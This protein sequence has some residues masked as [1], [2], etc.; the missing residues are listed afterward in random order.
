M[1]ENA[2]AAKCITRPE[3]CTGCGLCANVCPKDAIELVRNADGFL[4]PKVDETRC[5]NCGLC[6]RRCIAL[7]EGPDPEDDTSKVEA[8][9]AWNRDEEAHLQ[10]SSGGVFT[11]LA[12]QVMAEGGCVF[13]VVWQDKLNPVY[14]KAETEEELRPMRGSKYVQALP[15]SVYREVKAELKTGR[16]VLFSGT[17]CA[18]YALKRFL[19]KEPD[20]L[21]TVDIV[22]HGSPSHLIL[23]KYISEAEARTGKTVSH[24]SFRDKP[25]GWRHFH[26]T[27]HYTDGSAESHVLKTDDYMCLF[28]SDLALNEACYSCPYAHLPRQGDLCLGDYWGVWRH[29]RDWPLDKGITGLLVGTEKGKRLLEASAGRLELR[30]EL[31]IRLYLA[32]PFVYT[33]VDKELP[34]ERAE[35]L[36]ALR[37]QSLGEVRWRYVDSEPF[38]SRRLHK[39]HPLCRLRRRLRELFGIKES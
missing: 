36:D 19:G 12:R 32:Q 1:P 2:P 13:G 28:L 30:E 38:G 24:V 15:L 34:D 35:V 6:V 16:K 3:K 31:F 27:L 25:Q 4:S 21:Y 23:E 9:G 33:K 29:H 7:E 18:V 10:S 14:A 20:N 39:K 5:I 37:R 11:A 26:V 22:C 17:P 8:Y